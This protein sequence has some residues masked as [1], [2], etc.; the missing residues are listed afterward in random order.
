[1]VM[2]R[3]LSTQSLLVLSVLRQR[4]QSF[5][6]EIMSETGLASGTIYPLLRRFETWG[7]VV[8]NWEDQTPS[9]LGRPRRRHYELTV[10]GIDQSAS[11]VA[12]LK[13]I[14]DATSPRTRRLGLAP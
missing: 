9:E 8:S 7:W 12:R 13:V 1:M 2:Q 5:G 14:L 3:P 11:E 10:R 6:S 4:K